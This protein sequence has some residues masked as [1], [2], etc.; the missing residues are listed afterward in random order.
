MLKDFRT[1]QTKRNGEWEIPISSP[2]RF[3]NN[4][5][6]QRH[7]ENVPDIIGGKVKEKKN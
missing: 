3:R 7:M 5:I 4:V 6:Y 2:K 1:N